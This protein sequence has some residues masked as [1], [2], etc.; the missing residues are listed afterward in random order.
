MGLRSQAEGK[1]SSWGDR[2]EG[3][4][5][6]GRGERRGGE[7]EEKLV[8][9][10]LSRSTTNDG[11]YLRSERRRRR[12]GNFNYGLTDGLKRSEGRAIHRNVDSIAARCKLSMD[13][14]GFFTP[15]VESMSGGAQ[16]SQELKKNW[17]VAGAGALPSRSDA[18]LGRFR[19]TTFPSCTARWLYL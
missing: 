13:V 11:K 6:R 3:G 17:R 5:T 16:N 9:N 8:A 19:R 14:S 10:A 1:K 12:E 7:V 18:E 2:S 4:N 15:T